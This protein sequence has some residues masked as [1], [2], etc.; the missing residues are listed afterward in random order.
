MEICECR[1]EKVE[2]AQKEHLYDFSNIESF[3]AMTF[4]TFNVRGR[5]NA[6]DINK[7]M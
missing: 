7:S 6:K 4:D 2:K 5:G 1:R 3:R